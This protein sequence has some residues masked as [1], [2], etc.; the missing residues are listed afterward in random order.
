MR[1]GVL[2][3]DLMCLLLSSLSPFDVIRLGVTCHALK[4]RVLDNSRLWHFFSVRFFGDECEGDRES[5]SSRRFIRFFFC[6]RRL[7]FP[8]LSDGDIVKICL[9]GAKETGK[10]AFLQAAMT[11]K[12]PSAPLRPTRGVEYG[13]FFSGQ[14]K[15]RIWDLSGDE[16]YAG[17]VRA[18]VRGSLFVFFFFDLSRKDSWLESLKIASSVAAQY[19]EL[20]TVV[21]IGSKSDLQEKK[22]GAEEEKNGGEE[23]KDE[24]G[25]FFDSILDELQRE[26]HLSYRPLFFLSSCNDPDSISQIFSSLFSTK[27]FRRICDE[28][29]VPIET[30]K[31][32]KFNEWLWGKK[33][34]LSRFLRMVGEKL[35]WETSNA[36]PFYLTGYD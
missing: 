7:S 34:F 16:R 20:Q 17:L 24:C 11:G 32:E 35:S 23:K 25:G 12:K 30:R 21:V 14:K 28:A 33:D 13:S 4:R 36:S 18:Y 2:N 5:H 26:L 1:G 22:K 27:C 10:S 6:P 8:H 15:I 29:K 3:G 19:H 9:H 31:K